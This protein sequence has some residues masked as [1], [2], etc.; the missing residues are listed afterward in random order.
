[1]RSDSRYLSLNNFSGVLPGVAGWQA[2]RNAVDRFI[3]WQFTTDDAQIKLRRLY[4]VAQETTSK[5]T[6]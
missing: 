6:V 2:Q 4:P 1:V 3:D 5:N